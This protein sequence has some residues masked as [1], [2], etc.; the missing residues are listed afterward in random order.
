MTRSGVLSTLTA[1]SAPLLSVTLTA[2][3]Q[4][5]STPPTD[6]EEPSRVESSAPPVATEIPSP[7]AELPYSGM[8]P[9]TVPAYP[10]VGGTYPGMGMGMGS[11]TESVSPRYE[12]GPGSTTGPQP[13]LMHGTGMYPMMTTMIKPRTSPNEVRARLEAIEARMQRIEALLQERK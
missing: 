12:R 3:P 2:E 6:G 5:P 11:W 13:R 8:D 9:T 7:E 1:G 10:Y 4:H